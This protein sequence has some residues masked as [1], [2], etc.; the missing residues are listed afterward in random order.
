VRDNPATMPGHRVEIE[1]CTGCRFLARA[2]W[3]AQELLTTFEDEL[4][5]V[6][7]VPGSGGILEVR[8]DGRRLWSRADDGAAIDP[9]VVKRRVRDVIAPDRSLGHTDSR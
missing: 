9:K 3:L 7:L 6:A 8:I 2:S 5:A 1:Y 4:E